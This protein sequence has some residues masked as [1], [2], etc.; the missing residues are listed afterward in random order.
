MEQALLQ[1]QAVGSSLA[2]TSVTASLPHGTWDVYT[3]VTSFVWKS[4]L[5]FVGNITVTRRLLSPSA[6]ARVECQLL[7]L[8]RAELLPAVRLQVSNRAQPRDRS[9]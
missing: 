2:D 6:G 4:T 7:N 9:V 3:V 5:S 1:G 8:T